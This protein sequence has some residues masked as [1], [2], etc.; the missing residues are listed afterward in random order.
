VIQSYIRMAAIAAVAGALLI[1]GWQW[2]ARGQRIDSLLSDVAQI[3]AERNQCRSE[4]QATDTA[5]AQMRAAGEAD[6]IS[7]EAAER[8]AAQASADAER[9]V[10]AALT[11]RVPSECPAAMAWLGDYGRTLARGWGAER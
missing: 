9:R 10:R 11:A 2:Y 7:R 3:T 5:L 1:V 4:Q 8:A 6:R